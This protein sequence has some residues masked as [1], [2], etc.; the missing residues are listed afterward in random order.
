MTST[1]NMSS[2]IQNVT[3]PWVPLDEFDWS[4]ARS[5]PLPWNKTVWSLLAVF[6]ALPIWTTVEL[7]FT[8][9]YIFRRYTGLYFWSVLITTWGVTLHAIGF[10]LKFC[11]P[12]FNWI[13]ATVLAEIGWVGMVSGFSVV[14]F[15]RL[16]LVVRSRTVRKW[17][18]VMIIA[19]AFCFHVPTIV[20]QF[21]V[22][23]KSTH[24]KYLPY[25]APMERV[26][27]M[28]FSV[29]ETIIS[30][31]YIYF[32]LQYLKT[33]F[34][35]STRKTI[36]LLVAIQV[37]VVLADIVVIT[38]DYCEYFTLKAVLHSFVYAVKLQL[39]FVVLNDVKAMASKGGLTP[40]NIGQAQLH[41][42]SGASGNIT[43]PS[44]TPS[45]KRWWFS[46]LGLPSSTSIHPT[47]NM[48]PP[49]SDENQTVS[50]NPISLPEIDLSSPSQLSLDTTEKGKAAVP[51]SPTGVAPFEFDFLTSPVHDDHD[52]IERQ[53][54]G[55]YRE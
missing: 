18:L 53:Y 34:Q 39:E 5:G 32:T 49:A 27:V 23:N 17:T 12:Q 45:P 51:M 26:Q 48:S 3:V 33:S 38:L 46:R 52:D 42:D 47:N 50:A 55:R 6:T 2:H 29:Q 25:M 14:L 31:L 4:F 20:F 10:I 54:L 16:G 11:V 7:T 22:S 8:I 15:S 35:K 43:P 13:L 40:S 24:K 44:S 30:A 41:V 9:F 19:D 28:A 36:A 37:T 1:E 21:A